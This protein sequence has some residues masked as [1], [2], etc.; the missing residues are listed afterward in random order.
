MVRFEEMK[1]KRNRLVPNVRGSGVRTNVRSVR[2]ADEFWELCERVSALQK[3]NVNELVVRATLRY[4]NKILRGRGLEN[5]E[6]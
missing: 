2:A 1:I 3:T 5:G 4:C 6:E